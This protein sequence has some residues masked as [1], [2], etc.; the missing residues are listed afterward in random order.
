MTKT[1][2]SCAEVV[3]AQISHTPWKSSTSED[4]EDQNNG[5]SLSQ[6]LTEGALTEQSRQVPSSGLQTPEQMP[7]PP[8]VTLTKR[9]N[10]RARVRQT[11]TASTW[12]KCCSQSQH[13]G[14]LLQTESNTRNLL[15]SSPHL[16][17]YVFFSSLSPDDKDGNEATK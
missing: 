6:T 3:T 7:P 10:E 14:K 17:L 12:S 5:S 11:D 4:P 2:I 15:R 1:R 9:E 13:S 8:P 16:K